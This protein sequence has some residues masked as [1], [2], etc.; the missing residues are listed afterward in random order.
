MPRAKIRRSIRQLSGTEYSLLPTKRPPN[1]KKGLH[2]KFRQ[3]IQN[4]ARCNRL[5][6][7]VCPNKHTS[8]FPAEAVSMMTQKARMSTT[9]LEGSIQAC[10]IKFQ[11]GVEWDID[12]QG[13]Q[14]LQKNHLAV[15]SPRTRTHHTAT[16]NST[17]LGRR[18]RPITDRPPSGCAINPESRKRI[19]WDCLAMVALFV[20]V[21]TAPLQVYL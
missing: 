12:D 2:N 4:V 21:L 14:D 13:I 16:L 9:D 3:I 7:S 5:T 10:E 18:L 6:K 11:I 1:R 19:A 15:T 8:T 17:T 20:E